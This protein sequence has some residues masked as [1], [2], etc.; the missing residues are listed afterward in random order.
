MLDLE[1][2]PRFPLR[3][4]HAPTRRPG[5]RTKAN[6]QRAV[7]MLDPRPVRD[8]RYHVFLAIEAGRMRIDPKH[9][10]QG[11]PDLRAH[12]DRFHWESPASSLTCLFL[13]AQ[14]RWNRSRQPRR[15]T[16]APRTW[17]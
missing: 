13:R 7:P 11:L 9:G 12:P 17:F 10:N 2:T 15:P 14:Y 1:R 4:D 8:G 5:L 6:D 16:S 3:L